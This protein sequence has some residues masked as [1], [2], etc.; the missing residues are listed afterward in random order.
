MYVYPSHHTLVSVGSLVT[1]AHRHDLHVIM[2]TLTNASTNLMVE[3]EQ[4]LHKRARMRKQ[5][6]RATVSQESR[7]REDRVRK[8]KMSSQTRH[9]TQRALSLLS[10]TDLF[11]DF[12]K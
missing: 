1:L 11:V 2:L 8:D 12:N 7:T 5:K 4:S 6:Q 9:V 10:S 3:L